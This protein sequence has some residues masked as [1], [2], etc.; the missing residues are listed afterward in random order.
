[1]EYFPA[2]KKN[3]ILPFA[4][5]SREYDAKQNKSCCH[6]LQR[7]TNKISFIMWNFRRKTNEQRGKKK[8]ET[9]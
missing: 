1:M 7:K 8:R 3:E 6:Y 4:T 2:T 9:T 5:I